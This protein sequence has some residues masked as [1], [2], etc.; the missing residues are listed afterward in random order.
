MKADDPFVQ[1]VSEPLLLDHVRPF[2]VMRPEPLTT[3]A[4][5]SELH[6]GQTHGTMVNMAFGHLPANYSPELWI[7]AHFLLDREVPGEENMCSNRLSEEQFPSFGMQH[8]L[9]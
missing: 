5:G 9:R 1:K 8:P 6:V 7:G 4:T 2:D 3:L